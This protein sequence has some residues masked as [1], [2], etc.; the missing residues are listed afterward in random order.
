ME[1]QVEIDPR[2][3][4]NGDASASQ[5]SG[6]QIGRENLSDSV[7]PHETYEGRH[8]YDPG[9]TWTKQEERKVVRKTDLYLL[10]W[11]CVMVRQFS[12]SYDKRMANRCSSLVFSWIAA[13]FRMHWR[14]TF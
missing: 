11:I 9:A 14:T 13:I 12:T 4:S 1:K 7:A 8:R 10:S 3:V 2:K 5:I 6:V